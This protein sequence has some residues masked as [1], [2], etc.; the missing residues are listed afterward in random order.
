[1]LI[2]RKHKF[3][4]L[5]AAKTGGSSVTVLLSR[6]KGPWD[7]QVGVAKDAAAAGVLPNAR[8]FA[9]LLQPRCL[10]KTVWSLIR[11]GPNMGALNVAHK[12]YYTGLMGP[13][14][15]ESIANYFPQEWSS[16]FKFAVVRNPYDRIASQYFWQGGPK[17]GYSFLDFLKMH[18]ARDYS[19]FRYMPS[20]TDV[21]FIDGVFCLD[22]F[23]RFERMEED[24]SL[25]MNSLGLPDLSR[26]LPQ[27]KAS[28]TAQ[29]EKYATMY[30]LPEQ[31][32]LLELCASEFEQFGYSISPQTA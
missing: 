23:I 26:N 1:M 16:Y 5:H 28:S 29:R 9:D 11:R 7:I 4:F 25:V 2:S 31:R 10:P 32:E 6:I 18:N 15:A 22:R 13:R 20:V 21:A 24:L 14:T 12:E 27:A 30:G 8:F 3:I 19:V 17:S